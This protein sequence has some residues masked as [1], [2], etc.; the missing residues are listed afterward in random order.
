V[1]VTVSEI[2]E[3]LQGE[4]VY[5]G[6]PTAFVRFGHCPYR[7]SWCDSVY[8][9]AKGPEELGGLPETDTGKVQQALAGAN[10]NS[11]LETDEII[12]RIAAYR[13]RWVCVT[14]GEPLAQPTGFRELIRSLSREGY[15]IE[16]ETSG[17]NPLPRDESFDLV[18]SWVWDVKCPGSGMASHNKLDELS[19]IRPQDQVKFVTLDETDLAYAKQVAERY[20]VD[21]ENGVARCELLISPVFRTDSFADEAS[22]RSVADFVKSE[23]PYARLSLQI[24]KYLYGDE[25]GF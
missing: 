21:P 8:T 17:L 4:G 13:A 24:H 3:S 15:L 10:G 14:G 1:K 25:R 20:L 5:A 9:W 11:E 19:R 23:M 12:E 7:C 2:F 18:D 16:V 6:V 22:K